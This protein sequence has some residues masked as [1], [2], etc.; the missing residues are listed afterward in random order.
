MQ[1]LAALILSTVVVAPAETDFALR[2]DP[3]DVGLAVG[4]STGASVR[5][6]AGDAPERITLSA[7]GLPA[8]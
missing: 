4:Q 2:V 6:T 1:L 3:G 5:T 7:T 8:G